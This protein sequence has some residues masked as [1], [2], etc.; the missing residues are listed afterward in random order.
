MHALQSLLDLLYPPACLGCGALLEGRRDFCEDCSYTVEGLGEH[1]HCPTCTEPLRE[2]ELCRRCRLHPPPFT[3]AYS[4]FLHQG[5]IAQAI[6]RF[7]Y[8]DRPELAAGLAALLSRE[9]EEFLRAAPFTLCPL[10]LHPR[11]FRART[12][13]QASLLAACLARIT[14]RQLEHRALRRVRS[15]RPQV[16]LD[17]VAREENVR[18]AF[19][20][21]SRVANRRVLLLDDVFTTGATA[22]EA[23]TALL[24]AGALEVQVLTLARAG[25]G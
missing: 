11:R 14:A 1:P 8:G 18:S 15:T 25:A 20:A 3:R 22:R 2:P 19:V 4:A 6:Y 24:E 16:G 13:D 12:Y 9:A 21:S 7:K 5:A 23:S 10:P 17:E